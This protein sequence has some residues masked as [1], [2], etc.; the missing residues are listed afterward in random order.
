MG[1]DGD[2]IP[3][4]LP[5]DKIPRPLLRFAPFF[6]TRH[7]IPIVYQ[8]RRI[9]S[10]PSFQFMLKHQRN[11]ASSFSQASLIVSW[12]LVA[13]GPISFAFSMEIGKC[14]HR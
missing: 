10:D 8:K 1:N 7:Y 2:F 13:Y 12:W 6:V 3:M 5:G 11:L 9:L 4:P 14:T